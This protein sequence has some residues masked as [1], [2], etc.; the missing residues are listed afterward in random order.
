MYTYISEYLVDIYV[1]L[2]LIEKHNQLT[3]KA[4]S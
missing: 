2:A 3:A 1:Q 4:G